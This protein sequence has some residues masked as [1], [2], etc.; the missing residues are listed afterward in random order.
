[1]YTR[2]KIATIIL[3]G[4]FVG[5]IVLMISLSNEQQR[6]T[7]VAWVG[8]CGVGEPYSPGGAQIHLPLNC[9]GTKTM[10]WQGHII[11]SW[12]KNPGPLHCTLY[13]SERA[14]CDERPALH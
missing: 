3:V 12:I 14:E 9:N 8:E 1:M 6:D 7:T 11:V 10:I 4:A 2:H 5:L 13:E